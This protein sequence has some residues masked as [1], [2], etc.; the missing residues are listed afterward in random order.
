MLYFSHGASFLTSAVPRSSQSTVETSCFVVV[1]VLYAENEF[2]APKF[3]Y[4]FAIF[5]RVLNP[6]AT[7]E[8]HFRNK[9]KAISRSGTPEPSPNL[10]IRTTQLWFPPVSLLKVRL[11][12]EAFFI[13]LFCL[14]SH[15][16]YIILN[17]LN[18]SC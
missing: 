7:E 6:E 11:S 1:K 16:H 4:E 18:K 17:T 5:F 12:L 3:G 15:S 13:Y 2:N 8:F 9:G 14:F 10:F